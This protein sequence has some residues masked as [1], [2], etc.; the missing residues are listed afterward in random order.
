MFRDRDLLFVVDVVL[1]LQL[2]S[3]RHP[4]P[5]LLSG[6]SS[7][8][9][10]LQPVR[11]STA[12]R[13]G[14]GSGLEPVCLSQPPAHSEAAAPQWHQIAVF[15]QLLRKTRVIGQVTKGCL[16]IFLNNGK[17]PQLVPVIQCLCSRAISWA[18]NLILQ[19][20][21]KMVTWFCA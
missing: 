15:Q 19:E 6:F 5:D 1:V 8:Q 14:S 17:Y 16:F 4:F 11:V 10:L 9:S 20:C 21:R 2:L 7:F 3:L 18:Q 13:D 12:G